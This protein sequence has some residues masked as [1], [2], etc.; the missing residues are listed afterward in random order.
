VEKAGIIP[1]TFPLKLIENVL[2]KFISKSDISKY[3]TPF[4][5]REM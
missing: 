5:G 1:T 4:L 3:G 2:N